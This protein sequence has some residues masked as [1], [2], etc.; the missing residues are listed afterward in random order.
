MC[1][2]ETK[3][4]VNVGSSVSDFKGRADLLLQ[5]DYKLRA[6][7]NSADSRERSVAFFGIQGIG[8]SE[9]AKKFAAEYRRTHPSVISIQ[10]ESEAT[11]IE[12]FHRAARDLGLKLGEVGVEKGVFGHVEKHVPSVLFIFDDADQLKSTN[13]AVGILECI[14]PES[15]VS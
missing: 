15:G 8:K 13:D 11:L 5:I 9:L 2:F 3:P 7:S 10:A 6:H 1:R 14:P 12:S 4:F